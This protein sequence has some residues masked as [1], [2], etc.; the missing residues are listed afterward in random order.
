MCPSTF[1]QEKKASDG[2]S[3]ALCFLTQN[4]LRGSD[5]NRRPSG[6]ELEDHTLG[7]IDSVALIAMRPPKTF[8]K[9]R[10]LDPSWTLV[11]G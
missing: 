9:S 8:P 1:L 10:V 4:W 6:Y 5:L 7:P 11:L 3:E 2:V